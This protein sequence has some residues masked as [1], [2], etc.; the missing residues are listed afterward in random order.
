MFQRSQA[1]F[2]KRFLHL[3]GGPSGV[4]FGLL[5]LSQFVSHVFRLIK[6]SGR[7]DALSGTVQVIVFPDGQTG[8][9]E[10]GE[11]LIHSIGRIGLLHLLQLGGKVVVRVKVLAGAGFFGKA[12]LVVVGIDAFRAGEAVLSERGFQRFGSPVAFGIGRLHLG[13]LGGHVKV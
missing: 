4:R 13:Q 7:I 11:K 10:R 1:G 5:Q 2:V 3:G 12:V 8:F 9:L 6:R